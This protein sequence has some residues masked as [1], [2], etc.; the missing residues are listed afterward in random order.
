MGTLFSKGRSAYEKPDAQFPGEYI[1]DNTYAVPT[2][3]FMFFGELLP[4][5]ARW[6]EQEKARALR[7]GFKLNGLL[8]VR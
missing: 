8:F 3:D 1:E 2:K 7:S 5:D 4:N 6:I